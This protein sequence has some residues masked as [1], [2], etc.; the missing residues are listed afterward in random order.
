MFGWKGLGATAAGL[1]VAVASGVLPRLRK[2][3]AQP[4]PGTADMPRQEPGKKD[5]RRESGLHGSATAQSGTAPD[6]D[7]EPAGRTA[8]AAPVTAGNPAGPAGPG[9]ASPASGNYP[10]AVTAPA[11][12]PPVTAVNGR[13]VTQPRPPAPDSARY[14]DPT[15]RPATPEP[16]ARPDHP[17]PGTSQDPASADTPDAHTGPPARPG[18]PPP[19]VPSGHGSADHGPAAPGP[20]DHGPPVLVRGSRASRA[21]WRL[22][23]E[24]GPPGLTADEAVLGG[25]T[26]RAASV[27]GPGHRAQG[28]PRQDAY[29]IGRDRA[30]EHLV[31]AVADGMSDSL[32]SDVGAQVAVSALVNTLRAA[33]DEGTPLEGL[34]HR[35]AFLAAAG[36]MIAVAEQR[37]WD[38]DT[39]RAVAVAAVVPARPHV[40]GR[41]RAWLASIADVSAWRLSGGHWERL[42]GDVKHGFDASAVSRYLPHDPHSADHGTVELSPACVLAVTT[43]GVADAFATGPEARRWFAERWQRP[44]AVGTF[45]NHVGFDQV[46]M[47]DDRTAVLVWCDD[48]EHR[49]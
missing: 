11:P 21:P 38:P 49:R 22:P 5:V 27:I 19:P 48:E 46:Q 29:R 24:P 18:D 16:P 36:Q 9:M 17:A 3:A 34:D 39:V 45:L 41:R 1:A 47:H 2:L 28:K 37:G 8:R 42:I 23:A 7:P 43:D 14:G 31:I 26:V 4:D 35:T 20:A 10:A 44:P 30:G 12:Q 6:G 40:N 13:P 32:H 15:E 33:L 25:L